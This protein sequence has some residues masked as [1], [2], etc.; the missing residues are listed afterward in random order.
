M[1][2]VSVIWPLPPPPPLQKYVELAPSGV[3]PLPLFPPPAPPPIA[4]T[5]YLPRGIEMDPFDVSI[6]IV[7][8]TDGVM[9]IDDVLAMIGSEV[10]ETR[11]EPSE[12]VGTSE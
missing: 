12:Y 8:T 9:S 1:T 7:P 6:F 11:A 10:M 2:V 5:W 3:N 4:N